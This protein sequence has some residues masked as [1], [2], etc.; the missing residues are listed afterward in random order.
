ME[1]NKFLQ[2]RT[3]F[4]LGYYDTASAAFLEVKRKIEAGEAPYEPPY[5]E[6]PE[7][8][9]LAEWL[10]AMTGLDVLGRT[11]IGMV[12]DSLKL[13]FLTWEKE[14]RITWNSQEEKKEYFSKGFV[15]GYKRTFADA[16]K[17]PFELCPVDF[18]VLEQSVLVR[19]LTHHPAEITTMDVEFDTKYLDR[20]P[21][22]FFVQEGEE[23]TAAELSDMLTRLLFIP[24]I[25]V[26]R[27]HVVEVI[28]Q[29]EMLTDWLEDR[30]FAVKYRR[31]N[32]DADI[33]VKYYY[34]PKQEADAGS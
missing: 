1:I 14:F 13:Y 34:W 19:N 21:S 6:D 17:F 11:C 10:D 4:I 12:S 32:R 30:L 8:P 20:H 28:K 33:N 7:P 29:T 15:Q 26:E 18:S 22:P 5:S 24:R 9:F 3:K 2:E 16:F 25:R 27:Q 31:Y 23:F